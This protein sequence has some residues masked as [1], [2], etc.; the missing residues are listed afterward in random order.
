MRDSLF[1]IDQKSGL[2]LTYSDLIEEINSSTY[3]DR[4]L[5]RPSI[6]TYF[7]NLIIGILTNQT[8][9]ILDLDF[10]DQ[11]IS[12]LIGSLP[13]VPSLQNLSISSKKEFLEKLLRS[14][15][16]I[17]LFTSGTTGKPKMI[18]HSVG[19]FLGSVRKSEGHSANVW[20]YAFNPTHMAGLQVFF[21]AISNWNP[22]INLFDYD[23]TKIFE[24]IE[25]F[26]ITNISAS[27]SFYRMLLPLNK[28]YKSVRRVTLGGEKASK[29]LIDT[30]KEIFPNTNINNIYASTEA[31]AILVAKG[32][33][34]EIPVEKADQVKIIE[35]ELVIHKSIVGKFDL[36][37]DWYYTGD[38]VEIESYNPVVF[39]FVGRKGNIINVGGYNVNPSE[40]ENFLLIN[41]KISDAR[42]FGK[43]NSLIGT[44]LM[45][46]VV[47]CKDEKM[48]E[49]EIIEYLN[50]LIQP[51]K[52]PRI[53]RFVEKIKIGR[54]GK[55]E[56]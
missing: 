53:F 27:P 49:K 8:I 4:Y 52:I 37:K 40:I 18:K 5:V 33:S 50:E 30:L 54:T 9:T 11:E 46:E 48:N 36:D 14:D 38:L 32:E 12:T 10:S 6:K 42:V 31:G 1:F 22:L 15:A 19:S 39:K 7:V 45:A 23:K 29:N 44:L 43:K 25:T 34:F 51:Y 21:Q 41:A 28:T 17:E 47:I 26:E 13:K 35:N 24:L 20:G 56:L 55:K 3:F 2:E 16:Q